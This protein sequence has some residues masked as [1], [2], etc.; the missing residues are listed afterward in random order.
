MDNIMLL[1]ISS[2]NLFLFF[3][4]SIKLVLGDIEYLTIIHRTWMCSESIAREAKGQIG[5]WLT[6]HEGEKNNCF[7][8]NIET[9]LDFNLFCHQKASTLHY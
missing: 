2:M 7:S 6:G 3:C 4:Y 5:Y 9:K 1:S 8:K